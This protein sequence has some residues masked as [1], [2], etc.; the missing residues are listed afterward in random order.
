MSRL[1][2]AVRGLLVLTRCKSRAEVGMGLPL[3]RNAGPGIIKPV[4]AVLSPGTS[5]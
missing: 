1:T 4:P 2:A 3:L 5:F